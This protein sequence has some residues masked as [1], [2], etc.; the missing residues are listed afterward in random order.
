MAKGGNMWMGIVESGIASRWQGTLR[1]REYGPL[2]SQRHTFPGSPPTTFS[3]PRLP[4]TQHTA[5]FCI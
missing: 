1:G 4:E 2:Q 5:L 3:S